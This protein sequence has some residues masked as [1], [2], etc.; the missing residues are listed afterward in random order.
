[1]A[2]LTLIIEEVEE[3]G[4]VGQIKEIPDVLSQGETKEEL[5]ANVLDALN[6]YLLYMKDR[7]LTNTGNNITEE[8]LELV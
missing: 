3:G 1:M 5:R 8:T 7:E 2:K 4:Y 6:E